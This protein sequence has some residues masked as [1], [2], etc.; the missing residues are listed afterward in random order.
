MLTL[1]PSPLVARTVPVSFQPRRQ[2]SEPDFVER[3]WTW[4]SFSFAV[5]RGREG[6]RER[7]RERVCVFFKVLETNVER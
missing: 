4:T 1:P 5:W 6:E 7:E 3:V 2:T